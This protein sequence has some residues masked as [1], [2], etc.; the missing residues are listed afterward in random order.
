MVIKDLRIKTFLENINYGDAFIIESEAGN[1]VYIKA[2]NYN[3]LNA[4][5][6][7]E[8]GD[9]L[10]VAVDN[11]TPITPVGLELTIADFSP[12]VKP[13]ETEQ[14]KEVKSKEEKTSKSSW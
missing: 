6:L 11:K 8:N 2:K 14:K 7:A 5:K 12:N 4:V 9:V 13:Q 3:D 10:F 1:S